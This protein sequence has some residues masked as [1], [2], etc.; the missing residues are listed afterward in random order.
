MPTILNNTLPSNDKLLTQA[1]TQSV[2][3]SLREFVSQDNPTLLEISTVFPFVIFP[4]T[5]RIDMQKVSIVHAE[6]F[7]SKREETISIGDILAVSVESGPLFATLFIK[8]KFFT[9]K[10]LRIK[11]LFKSE[12]ALA[13]RIIH[14]LVLVSNKKIRIDEKDPNKIIAMLEEAGKMS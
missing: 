9:Q 13:R 2:K 4:N 12:A 1:P 6:F 11:Y 10:P 7:W 8:T 3:K 5:L 14:G